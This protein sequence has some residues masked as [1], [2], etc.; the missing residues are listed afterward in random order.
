MNSLLDQISSAAFLMMDVDGPDSSDLPELIAELQQIAQAVNSDAAT[1]SH[2]AAGKAV[3][4]LQQMGTVQTGADFG[5]VV[6]NV[7]RTLTALQAVYGDGRDW[8]EVAVP[9]PLLSAEQGETTVASEPS[10][11]ASPADTPSESPD[12]ELLALFLA[13]AAEH[14]ESAEAALL[15]LEADPGDAQSIGAVFRS[16]HTL[17]G[18]AGFIG[19]PEVLELAH[20]AET[21]LDLARDGK[22]SLDG[23]AIDVALQCLDVFAEMLS[24]LQQTAQTG[25]LP[26]RNSRTD[27]LL[28]SLQQLARG[29]SPATTQSA[30]TTPQQTPLA[31]TAAPS[32]P[33]SASAERRQT[34]DRRATAVDAIKVDRTRLD[35]LINLIG[36]LVIAESMVFANGQQQQ[37]ADSRNCSQ[38]RKITRELQELSL[39]LRMMPINSLFQKMGRLVRDLSRKLGKPTTMIV[40]GG[41]TDLDKTVLDQ[42]ADPLVHLI[43]NSLD[44]G[45]EECRKDRERVGKPAQATITL[46]AYHQGGNI[47]IEIQDDGRGL[48]RD[49]ILQKARDR[50]LVGMQETPDD[51]AIDQLI[52]APGFSTAAA[53]TEVSGRGVGMDVVRKNIEAMRGSVSIQSTPGTGT[54]ITLRLPLTLA[55]ID[56]MVVRV[57]E[58]KYIVPT[59]SI[60]EQIRPRP[61]HLATVIEKGELIAVRGRNLPVYRLQELFGNHGPRRNARDSIVMIVE[62][63]KKQAGLL[64][65]EIIGQQ[66]VVIKSL[67]DLLEGLPGVAGGAVLPDGRVGVILDVPAV[68]Q[69]AGGR[70]PA[71][72]A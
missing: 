60:V 27:G 19:L 30:E 4:C 21:V 38:L 53:V 25:Q 66:Q 20:E 23:S 58:Q 52:F 12:P 6:R 63:D 56:G 18:N 31:D 68:L 15:Q 28:V 47:Y 65:D 67:G 46:K 39:S 44:H 62:A 64:V 54:T 50:G 57:G 34:P 8:S 69:L 33:S 51:A 41:E 29:D 16:F 17:K 42:V 3:L 72:V 13:E 22:L 11:T 70:R 32:V 2:S 43:R 55:I 7:S 71:Q 48:N 37:T 49:R 61:E 45:I 10:A 59:L 9:D 40:E 35:R 36:E 26:A 14:L 24:A 1:D 5:S